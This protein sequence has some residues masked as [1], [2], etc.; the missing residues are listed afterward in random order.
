MTAQSK[1]AGSHTPIPGT[2]EDRAKLVEAM[3]PADLV[4]GPCA[5]PDAPMAMPEQVIEPSRSLIGRLGTALRAAGSRLASRP[6]AA[7]SAEI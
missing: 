7:P 4:A 3:S 2:P 5:L 1:P 6:P